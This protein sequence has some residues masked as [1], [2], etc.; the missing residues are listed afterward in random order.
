MKRRV[1]I[2]KECKLNAVKNIKR[3]A[4]MRTFRVYRVEKRDYK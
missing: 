3:I 4:G 1:K 2:T